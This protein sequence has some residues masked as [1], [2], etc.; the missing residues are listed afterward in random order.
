MLTEKMNVYFAANPAN[1]HFVTNHVKERGDMTNSPQKQSETMT[2][3]FLIIILTM[4]A[5]ILKFGWSLI[6]RIYNNL[7][8]NK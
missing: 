5:L 3:A 6:K 1:I 4:I 2:I 7:K 8:R